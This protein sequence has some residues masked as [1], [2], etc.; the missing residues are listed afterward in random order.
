MSTIT[1][2]P[3]NEFSDTDL[4][5]AY[6]TYFGTP[7]ALFKELIE[8]DFRTRGGARLDEHG[9]ILQNN[10]NQTGGGWTK[11]HNSMQWTFGAVVS[12]RWHVQMEP[13]HLFRSVYNADKLPEEFINNPRNMTPDMHINFSRFAEVKCIGFSKGNEMFQVLT[14]NVFNFSLFHHACFSLW[15]AGRGK[16]DDRGVCRNKRERMCPNSILCLLLSMIRNS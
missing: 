13:R 2:Y 8:D 5:L 3:N 12:P 14:P 6:A 16:Y 10:K 15:W 7:P 9:D 1:P 4:H 11:R